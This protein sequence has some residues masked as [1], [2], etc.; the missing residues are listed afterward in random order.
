M[1]KLL[2]A[3]PKRTTSEVMD[4]LMTK[5]NW[6][7]ALAVRYEEGREEGLR[8]AREEGIL[9]KM[10]RNALAE[11]LDIGLIQ[12][13]TGLDE[14]TIRNLSREKSNH[15][16]SRRSTESISGDKRFSPP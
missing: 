16:V 13:I 6:D 5:W 10:A 2:R 1:R 7:D 11:G 3:F 14:E 12:C 9:T 15:G 8:I 4:M